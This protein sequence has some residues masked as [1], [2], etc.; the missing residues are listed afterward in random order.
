MKIFISV[1]MEGIWG[2]VS[3]SHV[4]S[5]TSEY[6]RMRRLMTKEAN[7]VI[8]EVF[9]NGATEVI[10]NDSHDNMDNLL[11]EELDPRAQLISGS[12]KPL[13]MMQGIDHTFDGII[14]IGYHTRCGTP[15]GVFNHTYM[16]STIS[17]IFINGKEAGECGI[18]AGVGG[19]FGIPVL[20][21][22]GDDLL[23]AQAIEEIGDIETI[24]VKRAVSRYV[25]HNLSYNDLKK[26]YGE[27]LKNAFE[28]IKSYPVIK[29]EGNTTMDIEFVSE[30]KAEN[31]MLLPQAKR[32]NNKTIRIESDDYLELFMLFRA[33]MVLGGA[34][35]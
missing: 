3:P 21:I 30:I 1:D 16:G 34:I 35:R 23:A 6:Q 18:N 26:T 27:K 25:A 11:I 28:N 13:S 12:P 31:V 33:C 9:K 32:I 7:L 4:N 5:D 14:F 24:I 29:Y 8:D 15:N 17:K 10:V 2:V 20:A 22:S 19:Y